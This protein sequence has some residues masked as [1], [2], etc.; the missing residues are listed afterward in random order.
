MKDLFGNKIDDNSTV[1]VNIYADEI[2][3]VKC[4]VTQE[5]WI[6]IGIVVENLDNP[7]LEEVINLRYCN[8]FDK[9]SPYFTKND[10]LI[11]W[12]EI[13]DIDTKNIAKRWIEY[14]LQPERSRDRFYAYVLGI[15]NSK[16]NREEFDTS[17]EFN[18]KYNRF[19][20]SAVLYALKC[21]FPDR[22][23]IVENIFHESGPQEEHNL[24]PWHCIYKISQKEANISFTNNKIQFLPKSH[25]EDEKSNLI[26]LCDIFL[27]LCKN[28]LHGIK[29]SKSSEYKKELLDIFLPLFERMINEPRN[30]NSR[31]EHA[32]RIMIRFFPKS[33]TEP[34]T[35]ERLTNQFY[36]KRKI[37]YAVNYQ[38]K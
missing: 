27:G 28:L 7:L 32:N 5:D 35:I 17:D 31:Y 36:T 13:S 24:F 26:Q 9:E 19:F 4:P 25:R 1:R 23:V 18:S 10:R 15:N 21:F 34:D 11:H 37:L 8:N 6:Y 16:L 30:K 12:V 38:N 29:E 33:K 14:I 2:Q 22:K 20:R 3:P